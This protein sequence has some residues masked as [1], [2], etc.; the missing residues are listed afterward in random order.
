M[1]AQSALATCLRKR[2]AVSEA[3]RHAP[4]APADVRTPQPGAPRPGGC[5]EPTPTGAVVVTPPTTGVEPFAGRERLWR[6][7]LVAAQFAAFGVGLFVAAA[8]I[9]RLASE[10]AAVTGGAARR[11]RRS[12]AAIRRAP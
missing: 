9:P 5:F 8:A 12:R 3:T 7:A 4:S 10:P 2:T 1:T 6:R 11:R